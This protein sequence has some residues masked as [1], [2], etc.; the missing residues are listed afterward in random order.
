MRKIGP[1][2]IVSDILIHQVLWTSHLAQG[3]LCRVLWDKSCVQLHDWVLYARPWKVLV[4]LLCGF[5]S[6]GRCI[7]T[8]SLTKAWSCP[9]LSRCCAIDWTLALRVGSKWHRVV[10]LASRAHTA[11]TVHWWASRVTLFALGCCCGSLDLASPIDILF[12][13]IAHSGSFVFHIPV[14]HFVK[15]LIIFLC[16]HDAMCR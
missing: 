8:S 2:C 15:F 9:I 1:V 3:F 6:R 12:L 11:L 7:A 14:E 13:D 16:A 10:S 4:L 5:A